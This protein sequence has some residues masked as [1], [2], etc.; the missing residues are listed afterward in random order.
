MAWLQR[1]GN[2]FGRDKQ[3]AEIAEELRFHV[4]ARRADNL[5]GGMDPEAAGRDALRRFGG[6]GIALDAAR[7]AD[8]LVW[9]E[10]H[11]ARRA[12]RPAE[13]ARNPGI[14]AAGVNLAGA[15]LGREHGN[16][17][18]SK[19]GTAARAA[20][21]RSGSHRRALGHQHGEWHARG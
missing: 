11:P 3:R 20:L 15:G 14:M 9:L 13:S 7:D 10:E 5:A 2:V 16:F 19:R 6:A 12:I 21:Q 18:R 4:D 17:Q 8:T 1:L